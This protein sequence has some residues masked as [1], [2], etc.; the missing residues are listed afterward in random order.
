MPGDE[1]MPAAQ[2]RCTRA[3]TINAPPAGVW[4]WLVQVGCGRAG[5]YSNDLLDNLARPSAHDIIPG[6][7]HLQVGQWVAMS[8]TP[9]E[10]T[11]FKVDS[12]SVDRWLLWRKPDS[13]WAWTLSALPDGRT[14]LVTR[15]HAA[16]DWT[17]PASLSWPWC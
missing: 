17:R 16:Y 4:P 14:R 10:A 6:L 7:Q 2:Y 11:A 13:T 3:V 9:S 5:F 12:F 1:V 8:P 15:V